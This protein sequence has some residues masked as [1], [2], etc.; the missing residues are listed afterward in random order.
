MPINGIYD[1]QVGN[2]GQ[3]SYQK[4]MQCKQ[5]VYKLFKKEPFLC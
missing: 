5:T 4:W 1:D 2:T 3:Y